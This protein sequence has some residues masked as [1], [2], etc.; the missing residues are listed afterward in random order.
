[1]ATDTLDAIVGPEPGDRAALDELQE[2][3][4]VM[5]RAGYVPCLID[6]DGHQIELP[7]YGL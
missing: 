4:A 7:H 2:S 6:A 1:M 5:V 3:L